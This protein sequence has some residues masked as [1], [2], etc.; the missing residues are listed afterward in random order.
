VIYA[1][2]EMRRRGL[3][4][5]VLIEVYHAMFVPIL[6]YAIPIW[7][8]LS[9]QGL[10]RLQKLQNRVIRSIFGIN[11]YAPVSKLLTAQSFRC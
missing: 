6:S 5:K 10:M 4:I 3:P 11:C 7:G 8:G 9:E 2:T 1:I